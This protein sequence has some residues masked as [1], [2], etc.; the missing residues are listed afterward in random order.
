MQLKPLI[1]LTAASS[2]LLSGCF[3]KKV[4]VPEPEPTPPEPVVITSKINDTG[5]TLCGDYAYDNSGTHNNNVVCADAGAK[6]DVAGV[7]VVAGSGYDPV[8]AGQD[9]VYGRD[10]LAASNQLTKI[11]GGD[12]GFDFTKLDANGD[13]LAAGATEWDCVRDN[14][15]GLVWEMKTTTGLRSANNTYT[16]YQTSNNNGNAGTPGNTTSCEGGINCDTS[17]YVAKINADGLCGSHEGWR[18]PTSEELLSIV[19]KGKYSPAIDA[20]YFPNTKSSYYWSSS[21]SASYNYYAWFV[22]FGYGYENYNGKSN[23]YY[24]RLVRSGQ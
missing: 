23:R 2:L 5:I 22:D 15:T 11:G 8:P 6:Q 24:V 19:H 4:P 14:V 17:S 12:A 16:W 18:L 10:A 20:Q 7:E 21:P 1:L 3:G 9:A 13:E